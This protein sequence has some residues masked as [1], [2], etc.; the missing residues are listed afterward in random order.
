[1]SKNYVSNKDETI[2]MFE[3]DLLEAL[4]RVHWSVPLWFYVPVVFFFL[5]RGIFIFNMAIGEIV[6]Y[7]ILGI[8]IWTAAEY[9][10]HR[11]VFHYEPKKSKIGKRLHFIMHGVHHD[12]PNDS[13]RLVMPL[14]VSIPLALLFYALFSFTLGNEITAP[15]FAGYVTGYL[16]YDITHYAVHHFSIKSKFWLAIKKHHMRHHYQHSNLGYGVS[17]PVWDYV[18]NTKFPE[19]NKKENES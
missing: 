10:L 2:R 4:S 15:F 19:T 6:L 17:Q 8:I 18:F 9:L 14:S 11:F 5:Y 12:Y 13:K 16:F 3:N 7:F 1:M